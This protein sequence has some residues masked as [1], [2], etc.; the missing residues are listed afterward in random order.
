MICPQCGAKQLSSGPRMSP[1]SE[2]TAPEWHDGFAR[3]ARTEWNPSAFSFSGGAPRDSDYE[4][5]DEAPRA[6]RSWLPFYAI[7]SVVSIA[8]LLTAYMISH[9]TEREP[10]L[11]AQIVEGAILGPKATPAAH[12]TKPHTV[13]SA[14]PVAVAQLPPPAASVPPP[15]VASVKPPPVNTAPPPVVAHVAPPAP[16]PAQAQPPRTAT[17]RAETA[18][19]PPSAAEE[20][21]LA[22]AKAKADKA[23]AEKVAAAKAKADKVNAEKVAAAK[24]N[25]EKVAAAK[26][27]ADSRADISRSLAIARAS[28]DKNS[29]GP[30]RSAIN[31][32]LA[33]QPGNGSA[34]QMQAELT[35][36]EDQ[37]DSLLGYARLCARDGRWVCAWHN[38]GHALTVDSSSGE[39]REIL[40][41]SIAAQGAGNMAQGAGPQP[42]IRQVDSG[43][44]GPPIDPN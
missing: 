22:A 12:D 40:S 21:A 36:R 37:R 18:P 2:S 34:L 30:A 38:A 4:L 41:R 1:A 9:R 16:A 33:A 19:P 11:G 3:H 28:L 29:L 42:A 43:P 26:A 44:P 20:R 7:G 32:A 8:F 23:N 39:A 17:A 15:P 31:S 24:A 35:S 14:P 6:P 13:R 27:A 5:R 10:T 25:A